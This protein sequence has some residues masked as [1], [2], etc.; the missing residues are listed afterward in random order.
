VR[1]IISGRWT[2]Q[3]PAVAQS[4]ALAEEH[5]Q[6]TER[7]MGKIMYENAPKFVAAEAEI[8]RVCRTNCVKYTYEIFKKRE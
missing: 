3:L 7:P 8:G 6:E 2:L 4:L 5:V 1:G